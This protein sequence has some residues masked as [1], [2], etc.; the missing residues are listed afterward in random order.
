MIELDGIRTE[1]HDWSERLLVEDAETVGYRMGPTGQVNLLSTTDIAWLRY[2][3]CDLDD[4]APERR[5]KWARWIRKEQ[6]RDDGRYEYTAAVGD[7]NMHSHGHAF[8]HANRALGILGAEIEVFPEYLRNAMTPAGLEDWFRAWEAQPIRT[9]HDVL[10]LIPILANTDDAGWV[11]IFFRALTAQQDPPTGTWPRGT[12]TNI[13]RTFAY[14][15]IFRATGRMPPQPDKIIDVML[16]LQSADGFWRERNHS[17]FSTMDAIYL[18]SRL[19]ALIGHREGEAQAALERIKAPMLDLYRRKPDSLLGNTHSM[20][21]V[22]HAIGLLQEA[23]P[24]D[25]SSSSRWRFDWDKP[26]LFRCELLRCAL[27][28]STGS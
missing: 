23:F 16:Q 12:E 5:R 15:A 28:R 27:K 18:L 25:F 4:L 10:G 8:W 14:S 26:E 7:G 19:P 2:A 9:H 11:D 17:Y 6:G 1:L 20:L 22:V 24:G 13:S 3:I 21:A